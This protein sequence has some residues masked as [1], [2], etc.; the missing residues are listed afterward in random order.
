MIE[1]VAGG[2]SLFILAGS[3]VTFW[4]AGR[5]LRSVVRLRKGA[6]DE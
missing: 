4:F 2:F 3:L 6:H 5:A 1:A